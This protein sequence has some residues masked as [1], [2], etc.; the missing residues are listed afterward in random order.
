LDQ[1][2][3]DQLQA[4]QKLDQEKLLSLEDKAE[5]Y[6]NAAE[7]LKD[8]N[9]KLKRTVDAVV[10]EMGKISEQA[11]SSVQTELDRYAENVRAECEG[12]KLKLQQQHAHQLK[13][14]LDRSCQQIEKVEGEYR[15]QIGS[16]N[17][18]LQNLRMQNESLEEQLKTQKRIEAGGPYSLRPPLTSGSYCFQKEK[19]HLLS[20]IQDLKSKLYAA[21]REKLTISTNYGERIEGLNF[22]IAS[23]EKKFL[24][25]LEDSQKDFTQLQLSK[26]QEI[27]LLKSQLA[28]QA[29]ESQRIIDS[30]R[31]NY[32]AKIQSLSEM[33]E[34]LQIDIDGQNNDLS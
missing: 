22:T 29:E 26:D 25:K 7:A 20:I 2:R 6:R 8:E 21:E 10:E 33:V 19:E 1:E 28:Q 5:K 23:L 32:G 14:F 34:R 24:E 11:R 13:I 16:L 18:T 9:R 15:A 31:N 17:H 12:E 4:S 27:Q 30:L 3:Q